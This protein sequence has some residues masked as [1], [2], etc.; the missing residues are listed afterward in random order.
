MAGIPQLNPIGTPTSL[1]VQYGPSSVP[2]TYQFSPMNMGG[3]NVLSGLGSLASLAGPV[4][5]IIGA[6]MNLIGASLENKRQEEFYNKYLTPQAQMQNMI[7]AGINPNAA[8]QGIAGNSPQNINAAPTANL[9]QA[10]AEAVNAGSGVVQSVA[11]SRLAEAQAQ[12]AEMQ[13]R[14]IE[15]DTNLKEVEYGYKPDLMS[16]ELDNRRNQ[17]R[18]VIQEIKQS[19][20]EIKKIGEEVKK[21]REEKDSIV[22]ERGLVEYEKSLKEAETR[23]ETAAA[24][25]QNTMAKLNNQSYE[26]QLNRAIKKGMESGDWSDFDS[27]TEHVDYGREK[28]KERGKYDSNPIQKDFSDSYHAMKT[29][30]DLKRQTIQNQKQLS[31]DFAAGK[32]N[33]T[34]EEYTRLDREMSQLIQDCEN[35]YKSAERA[36]NKRAYQNGYHTQWQDR[37]AQLIDIGG[38]L[39]NTVT[40]ALILRS[41]MQGRAEFGKQQYDKGYQ[42]A[43]SY[44]VGY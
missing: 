40:G 13:A 22:A 18:L 1:P 27:L 30:S 39:L 31:L 10:A 23:A 20:E 6:G 21:I 44:T 28:A 26:A 37:S 16:A 36:F 34:D 5:G 12:A 35:Q 32:T 4:G 43:Q 25:L 14:N 42:A 33:L 17:N 2:M 38:R 15:M 7:K 24:N 3:G 29:I 8:A 41:G 11:Q 19:G 9:G